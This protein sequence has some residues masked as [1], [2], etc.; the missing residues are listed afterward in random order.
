MIIHVAPA[1]GRLV[2]R[3][4]VAVNLSKKALQGK[5]PHGKHESLIAVIASA[6]VAG[7]RGARPRELG[8]LFAIAKDA[9][10]GMA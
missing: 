8:H 10:L 7:L 2:S 6:P 1:S 9:E 3:V 5:Q 4:G